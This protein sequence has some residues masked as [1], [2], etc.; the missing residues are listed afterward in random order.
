[1][2]IVSIVN[3]LRFYEC[4]VKETH[5]RQEEG[6]LDRSI[7]PHNLLPP[8]RPLALLRYA[9]KCNASVSFDPFQENVYVY[10]SSVYEPYVYLLFTGLYRHNRIFIMKPIANFIALHQIT[11]KVRA[12]LI[13]PASSNPKSFNFSLSRWSTRWP[14][15]L[16]G[17]R[18]CNR[19]WEQMG[20]Y[21][22]Y[23]FNSPA[24]SFR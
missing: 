2:I 10:L 20:K 6:R 21:S 4:R 8:Q 12:Y 23:Q 18:L 24:S 9:R 11:M 16:E 3:E 14:L 13:P 5:W 17:F 19:L 22:R 15:R 1:M 7:K